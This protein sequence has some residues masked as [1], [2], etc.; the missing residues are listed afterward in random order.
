MEKLAAV[1]VTWLQVGVPGDSRAHAV[2][3]IER[4][5]SSVIKAT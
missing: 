3:A 5:G 4:F 2:E 1:G